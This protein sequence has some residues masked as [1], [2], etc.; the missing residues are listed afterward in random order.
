MPLITSLIKENPSL[1]Q[2]ILSLMPRPS[3][4]SALQALSQSAAK[5]KNAYPYTTPTFG[6]GQTNAFSHSVVRNNLSRVTLDSLNS[7]SS[8]MRESYI[9]SRIAPHLAEFTTNVQSVLP[10]FSL[11]S[12]RKD[13]QDLKAHPSETF[14]YLAAVMREILSLPPICQAAL[15]QTLIPRLIDEWK[16]WLRRVDDYV[17]NQAGMFGLAMLKT[18]ESELDEF[19]SIPNMTSLGLGELRQ[20]RDDWVGSLGCLVGRAPPS[21]RMDDEI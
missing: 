21:N 2:N 16:G 19:A 14:T 9:Q 7:N 20:I 17:N 12:S 1:K 6:F 3:L 4:E 15:R 5:L 8:G 13:S 10:F 11:L 18:W